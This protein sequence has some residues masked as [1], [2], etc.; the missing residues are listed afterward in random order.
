MIA[1]AV[2]AEMDVVLLGPAHAVMHVVLV[3]RYGDCG[4]EHRHWLIQL[5]MDSE[6]E[7]YFTPLV[8]GS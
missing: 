7:I 6:L 2:H 4:A 8:Q 1:P 5:D 3:G